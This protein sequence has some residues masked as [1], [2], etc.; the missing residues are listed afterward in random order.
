[1]RVRLKVGST[2]VLADLF[3]ERQLFAPGLGEQLTVNFPPHACW[4]LESRHQA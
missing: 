4:V 1:V 2:A 3:N